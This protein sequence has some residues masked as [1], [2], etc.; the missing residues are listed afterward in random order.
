MGLSYE[1]RWTNLRRTLDDDIAHLAQAALVHNSTA[2]QAKA[3]A[4]QVIADR[5]DQ[6]DRT[7]AHRA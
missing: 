3:Q 1:D 7:G 5:M 6:L 4:L 2:L